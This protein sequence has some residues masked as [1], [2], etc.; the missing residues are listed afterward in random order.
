MT[1][2][3]EDVQD[4]GWYNEK[5]KLGECLRR[6]GWTEAQIHAVCKRVEEINHD[7]DNFDNADNLRIARKSNEKEVAEYKEVAEQ[8]CC[9][10][11]DEELEVKERGNKK[12][13]VLF[14]FNCGH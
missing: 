2:F 10:V 14:G 3:M 1:K 11:Y 13:I 8:G 9:G 6:Y 4:C 7:E 12:E 5:A